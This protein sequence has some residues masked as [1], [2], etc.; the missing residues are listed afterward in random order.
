MRIY[1]KNNAAKF[2]PDPIWNNA[3]LGFFE[4]RRLQEE[5][6]TSSNMGSIPGPK[7][8]ITKL[9]VPA[10]GYIVRTVD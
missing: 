9:S 2:D 4:K 1:L 5:E 6:Q 3:S 8:Y 10:S 7:I